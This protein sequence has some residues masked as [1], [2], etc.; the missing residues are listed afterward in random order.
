MPRRE[1]VEVL[2]AKLSSELN[3]YHGLYHRLDKGR[4]AYFADIRFYRPR[5][6]SLKEKFR[7]YAARVPSVVYRGCIGWPCNLRLLERIK[8]WGGEV[9][10]RNAGA[11]RE[12]GG[13]VGGVQG[14][15]HAEIIRAI[16]AGWPLQ[17]FRE[18]GQSQLRV[19]AGGCPVS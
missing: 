6:V 12:R 11:A 13:D 4:K 18:G 2:G 1:E 16:H 19:C 5:A 10:Q 9:S 14:Q 15:D 8:A 7:R 17:S 3:V